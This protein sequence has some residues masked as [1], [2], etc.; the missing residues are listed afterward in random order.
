M[1]SRQQSIKLLEL[2]SKTD[3][4]LIALITGR[5][6]AGLAF[7]LAR[8]RVTATAVVGGMIGAAIGT[9]IYEVLGAMFFPLAQTAQ[10]VA[11]ESAA[12][13]LGHASVNILAALGAASPSNRS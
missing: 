9:A 2:R 3:R 6:D 4:Q 5:L 8:G 11:T 12:R 1:N 10:P 13:L 7:S